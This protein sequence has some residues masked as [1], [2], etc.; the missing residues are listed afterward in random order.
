MMIVDSAVHV[1]RPEAPDRP[2]M[3]GR[4]AH[5]QQPL[6]YDRL[7]TMMNEA[8]VSSA[9][10][11]PP[12]WEGDRNDYSLEAAQKYPNRFA[13]MGRFA[14]NKPEERAKLETW[15]TQKGMLGIRLTLHHEWDRGW[16]LDGT[17]DWFWPAAERLGI[18]VML[19]APLGHPGSREG[20]SASPEPAPHHGPSRS[21][22]FAKGRCYQG[23]RRQHGRS[24]E[25][26][27]YLRQ[28]DASPALLDCALPV[29][30]HSFIYSA[31][32]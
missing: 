18:P 10:L 28:D 13:V 8:G 19:Y 23:V 14:I 4:K 17:A 16:M 2:W 32:R 5:L 24:G 9:V 25:A 3:P 15:H 26:S 11:V 29:Q 21:E 1:W 7:I 20:G 27:E 6:T 30:E 31:A 12:S 22:H